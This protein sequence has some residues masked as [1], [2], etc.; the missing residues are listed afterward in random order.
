MLDWARFY[1]GL[2]W[3]VVPVRP[4]DKLPAV[5]WAE[6]QRKPADDHQLQDWF[7]TGGY[8]IGLVQGASIGTI[9]LDFDGEDGAETREALERQGLPLSP[10]SLT[11]SGGAHIVL[12]HP[13]RPVP[14][15]KKVLPGMDVRG[16]GGFIVAAPS[17]HGV[18]G[19]DGRYHLSGRSYAW[20]VDAHPEDV[21]IADCP[22]WVADIVC[23]EITGD[24]S[25]SEVVR[26]PATGPLGLPVEQVTDG[27]EAYMRD[28]I[29]AVCRE[30]RDRL[31]RLPNEEEL[32][33]EAWP[34]Y[35][36]KVDFSRPGRGESEFRI[37]VRYT[38]Q[39]A[40]QDRIKGLSSKPDVVIQPYD[41]A[42]HIEGLASPASSE[43]KPQ[44]QALWVEED[45][46][47]EEDIPCRPWI[48]PGY[49]IRN[50]VSA[51]SGQGSGGKSSLVVAWSIAL[52][53]GE[54]VG[55]FRP[56]K[57][58]TVL[59]YNVEDDQFEQRRRYSAALAA[60]GRKMSDIAG[61]IIRC[62]PHSVGTLFERDAQTGRIQPTAAMDALEEL[63]M[64]RE[65]DVL[66][67]DPLA[68]LHNVEE[69]D[70]TAMRSVVAAFRGLAQRLGIAV[71][72]LHHDRKGN[73]A[74]GDMDRLRGASSI[75]GAVRVLM[76]LTSMSPEEADRFG[77]QPE[78]RRR[79]FRI[80]G[81]K[82]NYA[83]AQ[84]AEWWQ[85]AGYR[86]ANGEEI[87]ACRPWSPP[88][89]FDGLSMAA[90]VSILTEI[91]N[92]QWACDVRA[93]EDW[94]G[95]LLMGEPHH[96]TSGQAKAVLK[97]WEAT[98]LIYRGAP[99]ATKGRNQR[100]NFKVEAA[101]FSEMRREV[102]A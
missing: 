61:R 72:V 42:Q 24:K 93:K 63:C 68:E 62:G 74:P 57:P 31:G 27:R 81:A 34:Q 44:P 82:S 13:G 53:L 48:A 41:G 97:A 38:L 29:L 67:C 77:V 88:S 79:H 86:I 28:T 32:F 4:G 80:D 5:T 10:T 6:F 43:S 46:W 45:A 33:A 21:A 9:V 49:L 39:R 17:L 8:G 7:S 91:Q 18:L 3:S 99:E 55:E 40:A 56:N 52:A 60:A 101:K 59:N 30:L 100:Q 15:R 50:A 75:T 22:E 96:R 20:D 85:L 23:G 2:G 71:L 84:E 89:T 98:G 37:K 78:H 65:V 90:C 25:V 73:N 35:A 70:N 92:G 47:Q 102:K 95:N 94:A 12:R 76:T 83:E 64:V 87:A 54:P 51:L 66:I 19:A 16:D 11:G 69:N 14:T 26:M 36:R 1:A 58:C